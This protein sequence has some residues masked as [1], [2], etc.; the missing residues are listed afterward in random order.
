MR[1][2]PILSHGPILVGI[3]FSP[4][5]RL[6][7]EYAVKLA[8]QELQ[9]L[10]F[11]YVMP[12][13][14]DDSPDLLRAQELELEGYL[15][16]ASLKLQGSGL[17]VEGTLV[18][19]TP[20]H[21]ILRLADVIDASCIIVGTEEKNGLERLL[22]GSVAEAVVRK[23]NHPVIVVGPHAA[24]MANRT[25]PWNQL[26]LACNTAAG[27][28]DAARLAGDIANGHHAHLTIFTV[29][30]EGIASPSEGQFDTLEAMMSREA[31]LTVKPQCLIREGDPAHEIV[32]MAE[33]S[34]ADLL[35]MSARSGAELLSH[36]AP[37][38]MA[39]VLRL[40]RCPAMI[41]RN[42]HAPQH[43]VPSFHH[44]KVWL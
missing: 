38:L 9:S 21:E 20:A 13:V 18:F 26:M 6:I 2:Y 34:Q 15:N 11:V 14:A 12:I 16:S 10:H 36:L 7:A 3:D 4:L 19:G 27:V 1:D 5:S 23:S 24:A 8:Q 33:D 29:R 30:E 40:S 22:L 41:L 31:W 35:I 37:G 43:S 39:R 44:Q 17:R 32:Q 28:T 42:V 25:L